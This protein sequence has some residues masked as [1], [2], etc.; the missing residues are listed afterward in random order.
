ML[1]TIKEG[2]VQAQYHKIIVTTV[3]LLHS[4]SMDGYLFS[5]LQLS[6]LSRTAKL[7]VPEASSHHTT[8]VGLL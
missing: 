4:L 6:L 7:R 2:L 8:G 5:L 1:E 3:H